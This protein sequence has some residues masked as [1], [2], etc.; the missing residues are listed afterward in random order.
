MLERC[1]AEVAGK[2]LRSYCYKKTLQYSAIIFGKEIS[3]FKN[4]DQGGRGRVEW[5]DAACAEIA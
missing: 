3:E 1:Q 2:Y 5:Q 4:T